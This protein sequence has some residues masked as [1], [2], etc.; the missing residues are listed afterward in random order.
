MEDLNQAVNESNK[1]FFPLL[2]EKEMAVVLSR[3]D[4]VLRHVDSLILKSGEKTTLV[5]E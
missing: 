5:F 4:E 1:G 3:R 2:R